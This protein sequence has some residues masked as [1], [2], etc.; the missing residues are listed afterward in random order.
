M[1]RFD[2]ILGLTTKYDLI[3]HVGVIN[4]LV[5]LPSYTQVIKVRQVPKVRLYKAEVYN[6]RRNIRE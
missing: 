1:S 5:T 3:L 2:L 4:L 6:P